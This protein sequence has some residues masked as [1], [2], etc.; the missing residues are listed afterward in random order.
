MR[1]ALGFV[2]VGGG[3]IGMEV[4]PTVISNGF[5]GLLLWF[6]LVFS[7]IFAAERDELFWVCAVEV[8]CC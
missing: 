7:Y 8:C 5:L 2:R 6:D 3:L 4:R 1:K